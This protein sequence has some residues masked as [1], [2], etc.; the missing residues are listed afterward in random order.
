M[1]MKNTKATPK[2]TTRS[3]YNLIEITTAGKEAISRNCRCRT[4]TLE[5]LISD[6]PL[7]ILSMRLYYDQHGQ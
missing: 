1:L 7:P 4:A 5:Q 6:H 3:E 2:R